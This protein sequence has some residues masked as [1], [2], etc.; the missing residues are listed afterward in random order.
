MIAIIP[1][2]LC[3]IL[4][5]NKGL[6]ANIRQEITTLDVSRVLGHEVSLYIWGRGFYSS[7]KS[8]LPHHMGVSINGQ[9][10]W[11]VY[12][13]ENPNLNWMIWWYPYFRKP[14][15]ILPTFSHRK[16][17]SASR[18]SWDAHFKLWWPQVNIRGHWYW[19]NEM[20]CII[21]IY[22]YYIYMRYWASIIG[23]SI[24]HQCIMGNV[25]FWCI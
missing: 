17:G 25:D 15:L 23:Y 19:Y 12:F 6:I 21:C 1:S 10:R 9:A 24:N 22:I 7:M 5:F 14:P 18:D 16:L 8:I 3:S 13:M 11:M 20:L 2:I 4:F